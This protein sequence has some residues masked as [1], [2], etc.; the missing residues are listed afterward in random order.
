MMVRITGGRA[1]KGKLFMGL[2][3]LILVLPF[4]STKMAGTEIVFSEDLDISMFPV[5]GGAETN[6]VLFVFPTL[7]TQGPGPWRL[8]VYWHDICLIN[9]RPDKVIGTTTT[10]KHEWIIEFNPPYGKIGYTYAVR[11]V[12]VTNTGEIL[13]QWSTFKMKETI[14][15]LSWFDS[16]TQAELDAIRGPT[17]PVGPQG[18]TG[19]TGAKGPTG[20]QGVPGTDGVQGPGGIQGIQG[21]TGESGPIGPVGQPGMDG[22]DGRDP[23]MVPLYTALALSLFSSVCSILLFRRGS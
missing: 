20:P 3:C 2:V 8:Y 6:I 17:G 10:Y 22:L 21:E 7:T 14:P 4:I 5:E 15:K 9:G 16:L 12:V 1:L 11:V 19:P 23:P 18:P 13:E